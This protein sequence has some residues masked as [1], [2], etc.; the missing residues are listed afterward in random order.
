MG[1]GE[2]ESTDALMRGVWVARHGETDYNA[3]R[4]FQG[5]LPVPLNAQG[6]AQAAVLAEEAAGVGF[7]AMWCSPLV[8]TRETAAIVTA[9]I[10]LVPREDARLVETDSGDW[11]GRWF[12]DVE[13]ED[14]ERMA[15]FL[16]GDPGF[17]FPGGESY[18]DQ[19]VRVMAALREIAGG[20]KP[21]LVVTHGMVIRLAVL[22]L[23]R[24]NHRVANAALIAL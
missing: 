19:T 11:T 6:R 13:R 12:S 2:K 3:G 16:A 10:G 20:P 15:A 9:R 4:R 17:A 8:R 7:V 22:A 23:G 5:L 21:V 18:A 24:G 14:P 1:A